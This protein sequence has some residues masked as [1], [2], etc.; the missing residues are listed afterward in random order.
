MRSISSAGFAEVFETED[1]T[2]GIQS[3]LADGPGK[4]SFPGSLNPTGVSR[5]GITD[6]TTPVRY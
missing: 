1:A 4:A 5:G 6:S 2:T 3:F